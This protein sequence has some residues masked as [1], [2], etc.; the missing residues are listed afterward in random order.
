[1]MEEDAKQDKPLLISSEITWLR[2]HLLSQA[3]LICSS[4]ATVMRDFNVQG[5][6]LDTLL[7][8]RD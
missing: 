3:L 2:M 6:N 4:T 7:L 8:E 1:M 5:F